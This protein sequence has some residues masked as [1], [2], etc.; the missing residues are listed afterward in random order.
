[1]AICLQIGALK[2]GQDRRFADKFSSK[3]VHDPI[4]T[5][6]KRRRLAI[7]RNGA[8]VLHGRKMLPED[9]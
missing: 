8:S 4:V 7:C 3:N 1:M 9:F 2:R 5:A 6:R